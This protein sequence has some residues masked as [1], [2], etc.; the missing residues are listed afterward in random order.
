MGPEVICPKMFQAEISHSFKSREFAQIELARELE[1]MEWD[2]SVKV[3]QFGGVR[4]QVE[5]KP[6]TPQWRRH[7]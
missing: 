6:G 1:V 5:V 7:R 3:E 2:T 4:E